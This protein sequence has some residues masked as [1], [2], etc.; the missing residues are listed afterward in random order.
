MNPNKKPSGDQMIPARPNVQRKTPNNN[1]VVK[2]THETVL[3]M[4]IANRFCDLEISFMI[5]HVNR[6]NA[7]GVHLDR[8]SIGFIPINAIKTFIESINVGSI[9]QSVVVCI[10][11]K[12]ADNNQNQ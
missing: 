4:S 11:S 7:F 2:D 1:N 6:Q 10:S 8:H 5:N 9:G 3:F 12:M